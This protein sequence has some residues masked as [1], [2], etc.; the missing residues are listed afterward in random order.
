L[1]LAAISIV[2]CVVSYLLGAIPI[3]F[4]I[5]R[6]RGVDVRQVGS[7]NTGATNVFR[8]VG[9][10]YGILTFVGDVFKGFVPTFVFPTIAWHCA[11][12]P[13]S[14]D[15]V[16]LQLL[17]GAYAIAGH[18][19]PVYLKFKGGKGVATSAGVL[20]GV[21]PAAAG[22]GLIAWA[23]VFRF[24]RYV[25]VASI[26]VAVAVPVFAWVA[27]RADAYCLRPLVLSLLGVVVIWRH[28]SNIQR[29][30]AGT[31]NRFAPA[32]RRAAET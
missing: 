13:A 31:E 23:I 1:R 11:D 26:S 19:W 20:L 28:K 14:V 10:I 17:Y 24:S 2:F 7:G 32:K 18:N 12:M 16:G 9:K 4:L 30:R 3:G 5:G 8:S 27:Y 6:L 15:I 29:L 22:V 21:A 25:S